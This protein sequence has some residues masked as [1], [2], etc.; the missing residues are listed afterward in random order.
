MNNQVKTGV[1]PAGLG[2]VYKGRFGTDGDR[3]LEDAG[4]VPGPNAACIRG[5]PE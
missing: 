1:R 2:F 4:P 5:D 3:C